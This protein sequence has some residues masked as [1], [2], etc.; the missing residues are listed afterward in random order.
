ME[1]VAIHVNEEREAN[2]KSF[3]GPTT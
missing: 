3:V 1:R 2:W